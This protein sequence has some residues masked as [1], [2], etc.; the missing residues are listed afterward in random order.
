MNTERF[1]KFTILHSNAL[2][3]N[4]TWE[5]IKILTVISKEDCYTN[6]GNSLSNSYVKISS[7]SAPV[8]TPI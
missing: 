7:G 5:I 4:N 2:F 1:K 6:N 8:H 3:W